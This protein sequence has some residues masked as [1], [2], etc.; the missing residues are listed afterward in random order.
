MKMRPVQIDENGNVSYDT[1][2]GMKVWQEVYEERK[3]AGA[4]EA[5]AR[6]DADQI[7]EKMDKVCSDGYEL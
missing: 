4:T 5:N 1:N 3:A 2:E 6:K 7:K